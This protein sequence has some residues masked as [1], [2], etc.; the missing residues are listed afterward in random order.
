[1]IRITAL[2]YNTILKVLNYRMNILEKRSRRG[3]MFIFKNVMHHNKDVTKY[4]T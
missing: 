4:S 3:V 1:L 2:F